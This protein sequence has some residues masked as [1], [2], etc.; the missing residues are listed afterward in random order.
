MSKNCLLEIRKAVGLKQREL[1]VMSRV[2]VSN[3]SDIERY[4]YRPGPKRRAR[5]AEALKVPEV[6]IW[7]ELVTEGR[8]GGETG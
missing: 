2:D 7:P 8:E 6:A 1:A 4:G 5:I 3:I